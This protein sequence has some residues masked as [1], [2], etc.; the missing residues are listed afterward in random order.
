MA[1]AAH[2]GGVDEEEG[3][4]FEADPCVEGVAGGAGGLVDDGALL[5]G[6]GVHDAGLADVGAA[7]DG[8]T[9]EALVELDIAAGR[10]QLLH[11]VEEL[12]HSLALDGADGDGVAEAEVVELVG[13]Q[14]AAWALGLV[15]GGDDGH[16]QASEGIG[17][18]PVGGLQT[19]D[20]VGEE[21]D[22]VGVLKGGADL[23]IDLAADGAVGAEV[24]A[25]GVDEEEAACAALDGGD[26]A[27]A[28]GAGLIGDDGTALAG[29]AVEKGGLANVGAADNG[30]HGH[31]ARFI[32]G[33]RLL[34]CRFT[35][36]GWPPI[37]LAARAGGS[38]PGRIQRTAGRS[39]SRGGP[40]RR[41]GRAGRA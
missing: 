40:P 1:A 15:D 17:D 16:V 20:G 18:L 23:P 24:N 14:A 11:G 8:Q 10:E 36:Q 12:V 30:D 37:A 13:N 9:K 28:R 4:A 32:P 19:I 22:D 39:G 29:Q 7:D 41:S 21:D 38:P 34:C 26:D 25:A 31:D 5:A 2:A 3:V 33:P 6:E 27:V 35:S